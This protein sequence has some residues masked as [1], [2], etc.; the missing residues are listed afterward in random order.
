MPIRGEADCD[1][2]GHNGGRRAN[3]YGF[4]EFRRSRG[5]VLFVDSF[6]G[7]YRDVCL[8]YRVHV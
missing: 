6:V 5:L 7:T 1:T 2:I 3:F 4:L 8:D